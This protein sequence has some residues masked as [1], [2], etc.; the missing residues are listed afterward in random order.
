VAGI[1]LP[2]VLAN[3][4]GVFKGLFPQPAQPGQ[5]AEAFGLRQLNNILLISVVLIACYL[6]IDVLRG[7]RV[8][9][10]ELKIEYEAPDTA[11][12]PGMLPELRDLAEYLATVAARNIFH[13]YE[14]KP[15]VVETPPEVVKTNQVKEK[16]AN[17]KLVGISWLDTPE[18][19]SAMIEN[20]TT[21]VTQFL[22]AGDRI[23]DL[24]VKLIYADSIILQFE[25]E[26]T[27]M[28]L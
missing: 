25:G 12:A 3:L 23:D 17:L 26:E 4:L 27:E 5:P 20:K 10:N 6:T 9:G 22:R 1:N 13:P 28:K 8:S 16:I 2:P 24:T 19:A 14:P 7:I 18:S 15:V 21:G 11:H